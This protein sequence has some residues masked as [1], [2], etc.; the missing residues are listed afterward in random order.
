MP[1]I[2][3]N[4]LFHTPIREYWDEQVAEYERDL[5]YI[6]DRYER[7]VQA[8]AQRRYSGDQLVEQTYNLFLH[9]FGIDWSPT[10]VTIFDALVDATLHLF[11]GA[12]W[13]EAKT[14]VMRA[15]KMT[16]VNPWVLVNMARRNG[17]TWV[18]SGAIAAIFLMIPGVSV[19]VFS[20]AKRQSSLFVESVMEKIER[21]F[22]LGT[23]ISKKGYKQI[24]RNQ[25]MIVFEHPNGAKQVMGSYPSS[26]KV[27]YKTKTFF[28]YKKKTSEGKHCY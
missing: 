13:A 26:S 4:A 12:E 16:S 3:T 6:P 20:V 10:Q 9:G 28:Y 22:E 7:A 25:E 21:A 27:S 15:R 17:K 5:S 19:A 2:D 14:R 8:S 23:H 11:Y 1:I 24:H 18:V